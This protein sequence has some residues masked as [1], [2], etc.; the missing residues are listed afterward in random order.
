MN[1]VETITYL[2]IAVSIGSLAYGSYTDVKKRTVKALLF[3]PLVVL[4]AFQDYLFTVPMVYLIIGILIFFFTFLAPDTYAYELIAAI[5]VVLSVVVLFMS[6]FY[7]GFQL[8]VM[9]MVFV[10][11]F[12]E[13]M[14]GIGDIKAILALMFASP[15]YSPIVATVYQGSKDYTILPTSLALLTDV[16]IFA[17]IFVAYAIVRVYR[18]GTVDIQ[19]QPMA[20]RYSDEVMAKKPAAYR[21]LEKDGI[22]Y[23]LY[24]IPFIVPI[25]LGYLLFI[26]VGFFPYLL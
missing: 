21:K 13:R 17:V 18:H 10:L 3:A 23:M 4:A 25:A 14:F 11:G 24:R 5:F 12:R 2:V 9:S 19:G 22:Q 16:S 20:M 8:I 15:F 1:L 7:W 6:G 26:T